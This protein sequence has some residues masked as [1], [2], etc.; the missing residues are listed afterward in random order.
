MH[1]VHPQ[2][3]VPELETLNNFCLS[4]FSPVCP[5]FYF[6]Q[7]QI[8]THIGVIKCENL[9]SGHYMYVYIHENLDTLEKYLDGQ[10]VLRV[11]N[12]V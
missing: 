2:I 6:L 12:S 9:D 8:Y 10:N 5:D 3:S 1:Y 4:R 11:S 7:S